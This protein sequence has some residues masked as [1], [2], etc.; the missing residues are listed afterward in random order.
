MNRFAPDPNLT[1]NHNLNPFALA[2]GI[3]SKITITIKRGG[4]A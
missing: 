3:K 1:L 4:I 2:G